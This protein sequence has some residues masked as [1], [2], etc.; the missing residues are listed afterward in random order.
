LWR[1]WLESAAGLLPQQALPS[2]LDAACGPVLEKWLLLLCACYPKRVSG[3]VAAVQPPWQY[4]YS[5]YVHSPPWGIDGYQGWPEH[6]LFRNHVIKDRV[7]TQAGHISRVEAMRRLL[8]EALQDP[9]NDRFVLLTDATVPLYDPLTFYQQV[10]FEERSRVKACASPADMAGRWKD[11]MQASR[12][13]F[14][15]CTW[16]LNREKGCC[17]QADV[18]AAGPGWCTPKG[19]IPTGQALHT[20]PTAAAGFAQGALEEEQPVLQPYTRPRAAGGSG[21]RSVPVPPGPLRR[22]PARGALR[23]DPAGVAGERE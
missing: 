19:C 10:M 23:A 5:L 3:A 16:R 11:A 9:L 14:W 22:L 2:L 1:L 15:H 17:W 18:S 4:L 7:K 12:G 20:C 6:S 8:Q 21:R 13:A